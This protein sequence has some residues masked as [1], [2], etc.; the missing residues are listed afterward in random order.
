MT[1]IFSY[2]VVFTTAYVVVYC[3]LYKYFLVTN[4]DEKTEIDRWI[5]ENDLAIYKNIF[6]TKGIVVLPV[7]F[8]YFF[9]ELNINIYSCLLNIVQISFKFQDLIN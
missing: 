4:S 2:A 1:L 3:F 6:D 9:C 5:H 8:Y 7:F